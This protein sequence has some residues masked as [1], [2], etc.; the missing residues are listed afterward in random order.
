MDLFI[1]SALNF[2]QRPIEDITG[3]GEPQ[4]LALTDKR[5][6]DNRQDVV[7]AVT[8]QDPIWI[9]SQHI[10]GHHF[11]RGGNRVGIDPQSLPGRL[12]NRP[13]GGRRRRVGILVRVELDVFPRRRLFTGNVTI[14][15]RNLGSSI[16]HGGAAC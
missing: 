13:H 8:A 2:S 15:R 5:T 7:T 3:V 12:L 11:E 4:Q 6:R 14:H 10:G 9:D 16:T 1:P